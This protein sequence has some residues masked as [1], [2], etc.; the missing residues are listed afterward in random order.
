MTSASM[1]CGPA[2][3]HWSR[4]PSSTPET[5]VG[6]GHPQPTPELVARLGL[7][8]MALSL[9]AFLMSIAD[10]QAAGEPPDAGRF[11]SSLPNWLETTHV[12]GAMSGAG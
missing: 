3:R 5:Q 10:E 4:E 2:G 1:V 7:A 8:A 9:E 12:A 6:L 11:S